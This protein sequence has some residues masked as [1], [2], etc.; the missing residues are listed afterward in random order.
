ML[1]PAEP[2][3]PGTI[4]YRLTT[5]DPSTGQSM[6]HTRHC[7]G[8]WPPGAS[9]PMVF[10]QIPIYADVTV[11]KDGASVVEKQWRTGPG[12]M[13]LS[14]AYPGAVALGGGS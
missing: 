3:A 6:S 13:T 8:F 1:P 4:H 9:E 11:V 12:W 10:G 2:M 14:Q 7:V 5:I